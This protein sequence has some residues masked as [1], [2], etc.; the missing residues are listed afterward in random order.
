[1]N[2]AP[3]RAE[4]VQYNQPT[5]KWLTGALGNGAIS[6]A[7]Y[8]SMLLVRQKLHRSLGEQRSLWLSPPIT[9]VPAPPATWDTDP[10]KRY[11]SGEEKGLTDSR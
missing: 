10:L 5:M 7:Q 9:S 2:H 4:G 11:K 1:M 8:W 3:S 6:I